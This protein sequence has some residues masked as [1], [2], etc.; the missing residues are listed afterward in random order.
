MDIDIS[1]AKR[2][3]DVNF[4]ALIT[5]T[6]AFIPLL[7]A[8]KGTI[9][10][11][12]SFAGVYPK[13][14]QGLYNASKVAASL[15]SDQMRIELS[16]F[17]ITVLLILTGAVRTKFF[18]NLPH[19]PRLPENPLYY[20]GRDEVEPSMA[21]K[22]LDNPVMDVDIYAEKVV[23]NTLKANPTK[24]Q[25]VGGSAFQV[26]LVSVFG[27]DTIWVGLISLAGVCFCEWKSKLIYCRTGSYLTWFNFP[28]SPRK[29][30]LRIY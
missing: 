11:N 6:K 9:I 13:P 8:S 26:W 14:W 19:V 22:G 24:R 16:P 30:W 15:L 4:F 20:L 2:M 7:I 21:G 29:S 23:S 27:W 18:D 25:W 1:A 12:G 5:V 3:F 28:L 17:G 10:N